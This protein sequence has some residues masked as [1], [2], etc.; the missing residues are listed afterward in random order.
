M[1]RFKDLTSAG[2]K[3]ADDLQ[4]FF[5]SDSIVLGIANGGVPVAE[6]VAQRLM[7]P[8]EIAMIKRLF[9][10]R[11]P[12]SPVCAFNLAGTLIVDDEVVNV[13]DP[14]AAVFLRE[15]LREF[16][17]RSETC[18]DAQPATPLTGKAIILVDNGIQTGSTI[19]ALIRALRRLNPRR[20]ITAV[21]V[22]GAEMR[23][24]LEQLSDQV[25]CLLWA[26]NIGHVG[27]WYSDFSSL[28]DDQVRETFR[29]S[30]GKVICNDGFPASCISKTT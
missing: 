15:A 22:A 8:F 5:G 2:L 4:E 28:S 23:L 17:Q 25:V 1:D 12:M 13:S 20:I 7:L 16:A 21:P 10:P 9:T 3:L 30:R 11:G 27:L 18:R 26:E 29:R 19:T 24:T 6:V 14:P